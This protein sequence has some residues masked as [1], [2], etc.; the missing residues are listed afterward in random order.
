[1]TGGINQ[2]IIYDLLID[3]SCHVTKGDCQS[4]TIVLQ[5]VSLHIMII[6]K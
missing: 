2:Q 3:T 4:K 1:M 6:L 5:T